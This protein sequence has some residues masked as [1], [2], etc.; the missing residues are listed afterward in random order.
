MSVFSQWTKAYKRFWRKVGSEL[1]GILPGLE[2]KP[3]SHGWADILSYSLVAT[4]HG[5]QQQGMNKPTGPSQ[6]AR[7]R[8]LGRAVP[9]A[10][11]ASV[12]GLP[13]GDLA[14]DQLLA[15]FSYSMHFVS[16]V[17]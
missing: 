13:P 9:G 4:G 10:V 3:R 1:A 16:L 5:Q 17:W 14:V 11:T 7:H 2:T 8:I 6:D 15:L 12:P